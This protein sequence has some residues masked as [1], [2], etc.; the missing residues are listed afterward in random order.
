MN[1]VRLNRAE[2]YALA[3]AQA[4]VQQAQAALDAASKQFNDLVEAVGLVS[5]VPYQ[6]GAD[7]LVTMPTQSDAGD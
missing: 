3:Q 1:E 2:V 4:Q 5:G 6:V 7:G